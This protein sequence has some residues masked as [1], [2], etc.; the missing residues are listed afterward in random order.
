MQLR[1]E[2][3][4]EAKASKHEKIEK[5]RMDQLKKREEDFEKKRQK[6]EQLKREQ[7]AEEMRIAQ[8]NLQKL[9]MKLKESSDKHSHELNRVISEARIRNTI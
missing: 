1:A 6:I 7:E 4:M 3:D 9:D 2:K 5:Q 8:L